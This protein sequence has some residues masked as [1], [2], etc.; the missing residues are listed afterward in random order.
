MFGY[1]VC[2][3][4]IINKP[5]ARMQLFKASAVIKLQISSNKDLN[6][7]NIDALKLMKPSKEVMS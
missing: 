2:F 6:T 4:V 5:S 3:V 1:L 7:G